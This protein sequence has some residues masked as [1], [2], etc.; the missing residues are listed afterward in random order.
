MAKSK[1]TREMLLEVGILYQNPHSP[2]A[3]RVLG[4]VVARYNRGAKLLLVKSGLMFERKWPA[5][6]RLLQVRF[7]LLV[8]DENALAAKVVKKALR[9]RPPIDDLLRE[10]LR[11]FFVQAKD[12]DSTKGASLK[13]P[14]AYWQEACASLARDVEQWRQE[15]VTISETTPDHF[16]IF[17]ADY[18]LSPIEW[19]AASDESSDSD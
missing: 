5:W 14:E 10:V 13:A 12:W 3:D 16:R 11:C 19:L 17:K 1:L 4:N 6:M 7:I 18:S 2:L 8:C 9:S 15:G